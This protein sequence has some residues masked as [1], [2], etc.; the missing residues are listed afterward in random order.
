MKHHFGD[1]LDREG[2]YWH[3]IPNAKRWAYHHGDLT[4]APANTDILTLTRNDKNWRYVTRLEHLR[5]LTLHEPS[6]EQLEC[7]DEL[8]NLRRL[9]ITHAQPKNLNFLTNLNDLQELVLEYV[10]GIEELS[11]VGNLPKLR[12][13]HLENLRRVKDFSG[14]Q[15]S[16]SLRYISVDG[17]M[18]WRQPIET[19]DFLASIRTIEVLRLM[20]VRLLSPYPVFASL[21]EAPRLRKVVIAMN[22]V[23]LKDFAYLHARRPDVDGAVRPAFV[24]H[25]AERRPVHP[26]DI[27]FRMP[28]AEFLK[29][30]RALIDDEGHRFID[31][32]SRAF[33]LGKGARYVEGERHKVEDACRVHAEQYEHLIAEQRSR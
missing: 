21:V 10:S 24:F 30:T 17:T 7:V 8:T 2:D 5:E 20:A 13:L 6:R 4:E 27:R 9:R 25:D 26:R 19:M 12:S 33:L 23:E 28:E 22:A 31:Q 18:D 1:F 14:L 15:S 16:G 29:I 11:A 32:P 3:L